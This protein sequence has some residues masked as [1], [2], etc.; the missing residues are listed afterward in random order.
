MTALDGRADQLSGWDPDFDQFR[1]MVYKDL[2]S[3]E[4]ERRAEDLACWRDATKLQSELREVT[5][6]LEHERRRQTVL[7][8][9]A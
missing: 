5:T 3:L 2:I 4:K 7:E 6:E 9:S 8:A 1:G